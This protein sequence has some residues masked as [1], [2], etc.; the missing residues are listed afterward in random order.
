MLQGL[1]KT[2][3][4]EIPGF[5]AKV[6]CL[7]SHCNLNLLAKLAGNLGSAGDAASS[8]RASNPD[9]E[10]PTSKTSSQEGPITQE[11][12]GKHNTEESCWVS[13]FNEV[14][15]FTDFLDEHPGGIEAIMEHAGKDASEIFDSV[16]S[17]S[18]L[19]DFDIIGE[20]QQL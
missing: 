11:E 10:P 9:G 19:D 8:L 13:L 5:Q 4:K 3:G 18:M 7:E 12:L 16:H 2:L 15:D 20:V 14:Y 1:L 17:R 6:I